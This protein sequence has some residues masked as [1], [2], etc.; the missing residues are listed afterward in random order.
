MA[1]GWTEL[2]SYRPEYLRDDGLAVACAKHKVVYSH[3]R[4]VGGPL[5][6]ALPQPALPASRKAAENRGTHAEK[7]RV[8]QSAESSSN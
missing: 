2:S 3:G 7:T 8:R 4:R 1:P 6:R 5:R